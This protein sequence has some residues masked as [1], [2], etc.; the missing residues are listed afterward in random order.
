M[1]AEG[2]VSEASENS[3][4]LFSI[5]KDLHDAD[6]LSGITKCSDLE[7]E[8]VISAY[9]GQWMESLLSY[10]CLL[11]L[12]KEGYGKGNGMYLVDPRAGILE[13][14]S[15]L[16]AQ[17]LVQCTQLEDAARSS[18][19][20]LA[21]WS[22]VEDQASFTSVDS[23]SSLSDVIM[24]GGK[25]YR[26]GFHGLGSKA[27]DIMGTLHWSLYEESRHL[28]FKHFVKMQQMVELTELG[29]TVQS[30]SQRQQFSS[31]LNSSGDVIKIL[32]NE[33]RIS[34]IDAIGVLES[35]CFAVNSK[36]EAF[37]LS[38][39]FYQMKSCILS[40][41]VGVSAS[42]S[43]VDLVKARC[44]LSEG[45]LLWK[46]TQESVAMQILDTQVIQRLP[47]LFASL[48]DTRLLSMGRDVLSE[49]YRLQGEW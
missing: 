22:E 8:A 43:E 38:P 23:L 42:S 11:Q 18:L 1:W 41:Q 7:Q 44:S 2:V 27:D 5:Y 46:K 25:D 6:A 19:H 49:A 15:A 40:S 39:S 31:L 48:D 3:M 45:V 9:K 12:Q 33:R 47:A 35:A 13:A 14:L 26:N 30:R 16:G 32:L 20:S 17:H 21:V 37:I 36:M 28:L 4:E 24:A 29:S 10:E 34:S